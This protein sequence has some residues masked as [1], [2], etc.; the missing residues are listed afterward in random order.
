LNIATAVGVVHRQQ[1]IPI[2]FPANSPRQF[3]LPA[4]LRPILDWQ[5]EGAHRDARLPVPKVVFKPWL[6]VLRH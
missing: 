5:I 6:Q 1:R 3:A 4:A 2:S